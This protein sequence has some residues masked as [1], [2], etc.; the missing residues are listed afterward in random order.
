LVLRPSTFPIFRK[1]V[2]FLGFMFHFPVT[3]RWTAP[4]VAIFLSPPEWS[5]PSIT[6]PQG[7]LKTF[8]DQLLIP[9]GLVPFGVFFFLRWVVLKIGFFSP[10]EY[11]E[12]M[13]S[14]RSDAPFFFVH[15]VSA[16]HPF[17]PRSVKYPSSNF[18][19][20]LREIFPVV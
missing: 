13:P 1:G 19:L 20:L 3:P 2:L 6:N 11:G 17:F 8:S 9:V 12:S 18:T 14:M 15:R 4:R 10:E 16:F 5:F 7:F